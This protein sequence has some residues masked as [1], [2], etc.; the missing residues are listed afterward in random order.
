MQTW[1]ATA[2]IQACREACGGAG[3]L[4][5]NRLPGLR[6]D[7]DVFTTFEGDNTV[8][9]QLVAKGLLTGHRDAFGSLDNWGKVGAVAEQVRETVL[10]RTA[11][12][13]LIQRLV[14]AVPTRD[15]DVPVLNRGWQ[16]KLFADREKH[17]LDSVV[18]RLRRRDRAADP[19]DTLND[20]QDH[21]L[22][23]ARA[24]VDR[25]VLEAFV[26]GVERTTD[27]AA[28]ALLDRVCSL[29]A[30][31]VLEGDRAWLLEHDRLTVARSKS[32]T[33]A[34]NALL[35]ELRP[36]MVTLVDGFGVHPEWRAAR[37]LEEEPG[38]QAATEAHDRSLR[39]TAAG[40]TD[41]T[42]TELL[43]VPAQ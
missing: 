35:R 14:D 39:D 13:G 30:L 9:M 4:A 7:I 43:V 37:I 23:V 25:L 27:P 36:H 1:H 22:H 15:D 11:A 32:L 26:R 24:H 34:V 12:R 2:T 18:R 8:L 41:R 6:A 21:L 29:Y 31:T 42:A 19:F 10:E 5:E 20:V 28:R 38:R 17:L 33:T 16:L 40:E 3:Y